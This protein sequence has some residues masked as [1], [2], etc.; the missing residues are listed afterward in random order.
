MH[1]DVLLLEEGWVYAHTRWISKGDYLLFV[2]YVCSIPPPLIRMVCSLCQG[3]VKSLQF[4]NTAEELDF[5]FDDAP[6][7]GGRRPNFSEPPTW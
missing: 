4:E 5:E 1:D 7:T 3:P 2:W 6:D